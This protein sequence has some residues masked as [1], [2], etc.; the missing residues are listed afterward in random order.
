MKQDA[1]VLLK[2]TPREYV[3]RGYMFYISHTIPDS[4]AYA[5]IDHDGNK[6]IYD[7]KK[8]QKNSMPKSNGR[9]IWKTIINEGYFIYI[10]RDTRTKDWAL[11]YG[12]YKSWVTND[13]E[14]LHPAEMTNQ[15]LKFSIAKIKRESWREDWLDVLEHEVKRRN[16]NHLLGFSDE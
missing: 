4:I 8:S 13:G 15:H 12:M 14:Y 11:P 3:Q 16:K 7:H 10:Q 6:I 9:R 5:E 1:W 2:D